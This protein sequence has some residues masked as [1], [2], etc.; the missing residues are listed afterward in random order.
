MENHVR[1]SVEKTLF[2]KK[3]NYFMIYYKRRNKVRYFFIIKRKM[4]KNEIAYFY[5]LG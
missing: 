1:T 4:F 5:L 2:I 3:Y